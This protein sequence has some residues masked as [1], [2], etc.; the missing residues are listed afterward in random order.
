MVNL[1]KLMKDN[2]LIYECD[3]KYYS[4]SAVGEEITIELKRIIKKL[5]K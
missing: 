3:S 4:S 5:E 2:F 1:I